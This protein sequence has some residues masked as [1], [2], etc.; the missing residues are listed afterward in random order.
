MFWGNPNVL[1]EPLREYEMNRRDMEPT[2]DVKGSFTMNIQQIA[3]IFDPNAGFVF[4]EHSEAIS[5]GY[6]ASDDEYPEKLQSLRIRGGG[7]DMNDK[8]FFEGAQHGVLR[9]P[10]AVSYQRF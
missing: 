1:P 4:M 7:D 9:A 10:Y 5:S 6:I 8:D 3:V 2:D